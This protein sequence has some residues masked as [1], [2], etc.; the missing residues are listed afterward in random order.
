MLSFARV[1]FSTFALL[2]PALPALG[3]AQ[4]FNFDDAGAGAFLNGEDLYRL[5]KDGPE[6]AH[7]YVTG[8]VDGFLTGR[9]GNPALQ[10]FLC[11]PAQVKT[12]EILDI[13][14]KHLDSNP[15][16]RHMQA[17]YLVTMSLDQKW[18]CK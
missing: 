10:G 1:A 17:A 2:C 16:E 14:C 8:V 9:E 15:A 18:R 12:G 5:C 13:V 6:R 7:I 11:L 3:Q 4:S